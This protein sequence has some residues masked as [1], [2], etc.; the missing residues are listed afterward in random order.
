VLPAPLRTTH[1]LISY[2]LGPRGLLTAFHT[3][4]YQRAL[5]DL[6]RDPSAR[7]LLCYG[8]A[9]DFTG[10]Y[11]YD[12]WVEALGKVA[13]GAD[14]GDGG[15]GEDADEVR[16]GEEAGICEEG[17][18]DAP[19]RGGKG[20]E[21]VKIPGATHFWGGQAGGGLIEAVTQFLAQGEGDGQ[22]GDVLP[23]SL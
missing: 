3:R 21:V 11:A 2:P 6:V 7:V 8:D 12:E 1:V 9:D 14:D 13:V 16:R 22:G 19:E 5:E 17:E 10:A 4:T 15:G 20:L 18:E 23:R